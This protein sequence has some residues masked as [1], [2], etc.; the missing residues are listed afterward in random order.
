MISKTRLYFKPQT[1]SY[2]PPSTLTNWI[3]SSMWICYISRVGMSHYG[4]DKS[5]HPNKISTRYF[6]FGK[7]YVLITL[8]LGLLVS[9]FK[10]GW[11]NWAY[12]IFA[13]T[14][15]FS[16]FQRQK[17]QIIFT[18]NRLI[19]QS[20]LGTIWICSVCKIVINREL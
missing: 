17:E 10:R 2:E 15:N 14:H 8:L 5:I 3:T 20:S 7:Y 11:V 12:K 19:L 18:W 1:K 16:V 4:P 9:K 13:R 6:L